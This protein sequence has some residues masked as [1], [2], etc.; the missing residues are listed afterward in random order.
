[1]TDARDMLKLIA[2]DAE[3]LEIVSAH[4]QDAILKVADFAY[5]PRERRFAMVACRFDWE[6]P[7]DPHRRL[8][9]LHFE[10]VLSVRKVGLP[11]DPRAVMNL[12]AITFEPG[13]APGGEITLLF[14]GDAAIRLTVECVEAQIK[15]LGPVWEAGG[16]P[17]HG[18]GGSL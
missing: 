8:S 14:S 7:D 2:L 6:R 17:E 3:D 11:A 18:A 5:L 12:L 10:S 1:M 13:E 16:C 15:D 9:G 4:M